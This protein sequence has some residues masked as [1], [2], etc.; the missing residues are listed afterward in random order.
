MLRNVEMYELK[1]GKKTA[2]QHK[3]GLC[4]KSLPRLLIH[5]SRSKLNTFLYSEQQI[6][7]WTLTGVELHYS[8][9]RIYKM[10]HIVLW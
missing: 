7:I 6:E 2:N 9:F 4:P 1:A 5:L 10:Q 3:H 8:K